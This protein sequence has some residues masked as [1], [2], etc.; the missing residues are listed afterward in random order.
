MSYDEIIIKENVKYLKV[1]QKV[2]KASA[3]VD[4]EMSSKK[5]SRFI[6]QL[7]IRSTEEISFEVE[8][9]LMA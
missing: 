9:E 5:F 3:K 4:L 8:D 7:F 2:Q 1:Q 6:S